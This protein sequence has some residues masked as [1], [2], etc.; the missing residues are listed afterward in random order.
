VAS[1]T[2]QGLENHGG[3]VAVARDTSRV[4]NAVNAAVA[5]LAGT[6]PAAELIAVI[7]YI[8]RVAYVAADYQAGIVAVRNQ[9]NQGGFPDD[10]AMRLVREADPAA[11]QPGLT[12]EELRDEMNGT[13]GVDDVTGQTAAVDW[14]ATLWALYTADNDGDGVADRLV[15]NPVPAAWTTRISQLLGRADTTLESGV[16]VTFNV[17]WDGGGGHTMSFSDVRQVGGV[18][19]FLVHDTWSGNTA[20]VP[21]ASIQ[22]GSWPGITGNRGVICGL[23]G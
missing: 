23:I 20:W 13:L 5:A 21:E 18:Q 16:D 15:P 2:E 17:Y 6:T 10:Q 7:N 3:N 22:Q 4:V 12:P 19:Q 9:I 8:N 11:A 14:D 1:E